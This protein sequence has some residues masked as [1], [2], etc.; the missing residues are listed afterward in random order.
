MTC[1]NCLVRFIMTFST[2]L[3]WIFT[4]QH[5]NVSTYQ[6]QNIYVYTLNFSVFPQHC[7]YSPSNNAENHFHNKVSLSCSHN[8][9]G[10]YATCYLLTCTRWFELSSLYISVRMLLPHPFFLSNLQYVQLLH[11]LSHLLIFNKQLTNQCLY[12]ISWDLFDVYK[13]SSVL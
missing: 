3:Y 8:K 7:L 2:L 10:L 6:A 5:H 4:K 13:W 1:T 9:K 11:T 12:L